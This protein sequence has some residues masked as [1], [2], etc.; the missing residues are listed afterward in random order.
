[1]QGLSDSD[2]ELTKHVTRKISGRW[3]AKLTVR[4]RVTHRRADDLSNGPVVW[5]ALCYEL[6]VRPSLS[7]EAEAILFAAR[8]H[9]SF[10]LKVTNAAVDPVDR[11]IAVHV[12]VAPEELFALRLPGDAAATMRW[13]EGFRELCAGG[14]VVH[15][16][17]SDF[18]LTSA[19]FE[20]A[21][22]IQ[23]NDVQECLRR[24]G[25]L[26]DAAE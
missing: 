26:Q 17:D 21:K 22:S 20:K 15:H 14:F 5:H 9:G 18:S 23:P 6:D 10:E 24:V 2:S 16:I 25:L 19:G 13:F 3:P 8:K 11:F 12:Q 1:M 4:R 7:P